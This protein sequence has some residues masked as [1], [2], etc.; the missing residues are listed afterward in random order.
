[1]SPTIMS[2]RKPASRIAFG[3][4]VDAD[5]HRPH[6]ADVRAQ[7]VQVGAVVDAA[8]DDERR[9]VAEVG[10]EARQ[11]DL[12]R[13]AG[14]A[15]R[16]CARRCCART[17]RAPRRSPAGA[18]RSRRARSPGPAASPRA[19]ERARRRA[20]RRRAARPGRRPSARRTARRPAGPRAGCRPGRA[21][22]GPCSGT[23]R[24][25]DGR[26]F[27]TAATPRGD[28]V[29]GGDAVEVAVVDDRDLAR[30]QLLHEQLRPPAPAHGAAHGG[31]LRGDGALHRPRVY[32]AFSSSRAWRRAAASSASAP[33]IRTISPTTSRSA[34]CVT[35]VQRRLGERVLGDREVAAGERGDLRQV[36]DAEDLAALGELAQPR[37]DRARGLAA[38]AGVDLVEDE[39]ARPSRRSAT[40]SSASITRDSSPPEAVSRTGPAGT[41]LFGASR[42][43]TA[44]APVG[45]GSRALSDDLEARALHRQL[46]ERVA[47]PP[48]PAAAPACARA[49]RS[50]A[51]SRSRA[52]ARLGQPRGRL[53][54]R[55]LGVRELVA[56]R[57][58]ALRVLEHRRDRPA[59]LALQPVE[60][61]QA[62]LGRLE[63]ARAR[64]RGPPRSARSSPA[65]VVGLVQQR[66]ASA[67]PARR[68]PA[69]TP[70]APSSAAA[71]AP[72]AAPAR[73]SPS[74][75]S[76]ACAAPSAAPRSASTWRRRSRAASRSRSSASSGA[77]SSISRSSNASRSSSRSRAPARPRQLLQ[78]PLAPRAPARGPRRSA[79][80]RARLLGPA[81]A[82]RAARA[83]PRRA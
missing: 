1:M 79:A 43:S 25:A 80:R 11:L 23:R 73:P 14:P 20:R 59:V 57:A 71:A 2:G 82:R 28:Q 5:E 52:R 47:R 19:S 31:R 9:A 67:R 21:A 34:S 69:S 63:R 17:L 40:P 22:A 3:A 29:L 50:S 7:R 49:A 72:R 18:A 36:R 4:A 75:G 54:Q 76:S 8:H 39:R 41:P 30:M 70:A 27:R 10:V 68:A 51:A 35:V 66:R 77:T 48:R 26:Q 64:R 55:D 16:P 53:L 33:S 15:P 32:A 78:R 45:P 44:S 65:E 24:A 74:S 38:D 62:L 46:G 61:R 56:A 12:A 6:V 83:G 37:A 13:R 42:N 81:E 60:R 58:A